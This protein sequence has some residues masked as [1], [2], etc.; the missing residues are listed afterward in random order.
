MRWLFGRSCGHS[1]VVETSY[2]PG[3]KNWQ[4]LDWIESRKICK[5][6]FRQKKE[7]EAERGSELFKELFPAPPSWNGTPKQV[8]FA[9]RS[10]HQAHVRLLLL[11]PTHP[12]LPLVLQISREVS[13]HRLPVKPW[14]DAWSELMLS[15]PWSPYSKGTP[16]EFR[17][18]VDMNVFFSNAIS[19]TIVVRAS[20]NFC[21][22]RPLAK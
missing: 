7:E 19:K 3:S 1:E 18:L 15:W 20:E 21:Q 8:D 6:C 11:E 2:S 12:Q 10:W 5:D 22:V 16:K 17:D 14:L 4:R 13:G 9:E